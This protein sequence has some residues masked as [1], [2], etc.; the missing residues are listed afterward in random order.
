MLPAI[1]AGPVFALVLPGAL[2]RLGTNLLH[3]HR[4]RRRVPPNIDERERLFLRV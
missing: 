3:A 2:A 4:G 1:V